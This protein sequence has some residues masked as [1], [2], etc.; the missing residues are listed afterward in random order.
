MLIFCYQNVKEALYR[1]RRSNFVLH[2]ESG[3]V[4]Y[5]MIRNRNTGEQCPFNSQRYRYLFSHD[6]AAEVLQLL[7]LE[8]F[9][10]LQD[11]LY[12]QN[13]SCQ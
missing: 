8:I 9:G 6:G 11:L 13:T 2:P 5:L 7:D 4:R 3:S 1:M 10:S 12:L